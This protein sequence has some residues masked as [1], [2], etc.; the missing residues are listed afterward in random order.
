MENKKETLSNKQ[1][2]GT[3]LPRNQIEC[4]SKVDVKEFIKDLK[5][6]L[7]GVIQEYPGIGDDIDKL[8]G[9]KLI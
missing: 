2:V 3:F 6:R 5:E 7:Y 1:M 9:D 4:F 8:A